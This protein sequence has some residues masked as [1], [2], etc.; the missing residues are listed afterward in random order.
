MCLEL[1]G[2][3][4]APYMQ[5]LHFSFGLGAF[6]APLIAAPF[7]SPLPVVI[8]TKTMSLVNFTTTATPL[9]DSARNVRSV[10]GVTDT[11]YNCDRPC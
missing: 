3:Q 11:E 8:E 1:W 4:S 10:L 9:V 7:L 5:A 2:Q 6:I